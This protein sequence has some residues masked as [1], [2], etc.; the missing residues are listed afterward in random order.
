MN[1]LVDETV[2]EELQTGGDEAIRLY[3]AACVERTAPLFVGLRAGE[4][5]READVDLYAAAVGDLWRTDHPLPDAV[6]RARLLERFPELRPTEEAST[7]VV[8]SYTSL[9]GLVLRYALLANASG[10]ADRAV[11]CGHAALAATDVLD[12]N[13]G[14]AAFRAEEHLLQARSVSGDAA[15]V[16]DASVSAGR[17]RLRAA[18]GSTAGGT[19]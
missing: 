18:L 9:A 16:W 12:R 3:V 5:G 8:G 7:G 14:G 17:E 1:T 2:V 10:S 15:G 4:A 13:L 11:S 19:R 6:E